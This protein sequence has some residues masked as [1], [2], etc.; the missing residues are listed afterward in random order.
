MIRQA[1]IKY[2]FDVYQAVC[3]DERLRVNA[4]R[5]IS[6]SFF[7]S[8]LVQ[9]AISMTADRDFWK[10]PVLLTSLLRPSPFLTKD[11]GRKLRAYTAP[12]FHPSDFDSTDLLTQWQA[13]LFGADGM[14]T[15]HVR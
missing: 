11:L 5:W 12:G 8:T 1:I 9:T 4:F 7:M 15:P 13:E 10:T 6:F 2:H 3:G 14:L